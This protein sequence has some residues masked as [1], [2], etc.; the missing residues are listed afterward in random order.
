MA[1][2]QEELEAAYKSSAL[3]KIFLFNQNYWVFLIY[4]SNMPLEK[5]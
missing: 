2:L 1:L 5:G 3:K 4:S